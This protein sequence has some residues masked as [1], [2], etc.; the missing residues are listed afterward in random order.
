VVSR[1]GAAPG[2]APLETQAAEVCK[3]GRG[4]LDLEGVEALRALFLLL[5]RWDGEDTNHGE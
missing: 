5:D 2:E 3:A 4:P 1:R